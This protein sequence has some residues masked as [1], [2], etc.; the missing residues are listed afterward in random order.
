MINWIDLTK[1]NKDA[2]HEV[3]F[4]MNILSLDN[5]VDVESYYNL[6]PSGIKLD[7]NRW[8]F[9]DSVVMDNMHEWFEKNK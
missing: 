3:L 2:I 5:E 8:G 6:L 1:E 9:S 7:G 4:Q